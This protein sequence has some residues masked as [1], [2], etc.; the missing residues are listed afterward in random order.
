[1]KGL[2][3]TMTEVLPEHEA[4]FNRWYDEEHVPM[5]RRVAGVLADAPVPRPRGNSAL[6]CALRSR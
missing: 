5:L 3:L 6:Y 4:E 2:L 1:M